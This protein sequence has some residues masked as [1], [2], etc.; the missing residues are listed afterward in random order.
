VTEK[1]LSRIE[2]SLKITLPDA[3][4][5]LISEQAGALKESRAFDGDCPSFSLDAKEVI[6]FNKAERPKDSGTGYAFPKWWSTFVLIGT[7]G[8]GDYYCLRLDNKPGVWMI[9]SDC[10]D[11]P[12]RVARS[13]KGFVQERL[14]EHQEEQERAAARQEDYHEENAEELKAIAESGDPKAKQWLEAISPYAM[15]PALDNIGQRVS[16]R[17]LRLYGIACCRRVANLAADDELVQ[18]VHLAE[19][20]VAG[21]ATTQD[22]ARLRA[23]LTTKHAAIRAGEE[24][25]PAGLWGV[26]AATNLLQDDSHYF[27]KDQIHAGDGDLLRVWYSARSAASDVDLEGTVQSDLLREV[28]GNP[29]VPVRFEPKWRTAEVLELAG[30]IYDKLSFEKMP[31][32]A[33]AL[34]RAGCANPRILKH[35]MR[36]PTHVRGCWVLDLILETEPEPAK[37]ELTWDFT[38]EYPNV[39]AS[40]L[41]TR[42]LAFGAD[43]AREPMAADDGPALSFADWLERNGDPAWAKYIRLRC[44][45]DGKAPGEDYPEFLEQLLESASGMRKRGAKFPGFYFSGYRFAS[46]EWWGDETDD[47]QRGIPWSVGA[48]SPSAG[49]RPVEQLVKELDA[50]FRTTPVRGINFEW[51]YPNEMAEILCSPP[52][53]QLRWLKFANRHPEGQTGPVIEAMVKSPVVKNLER[54][55]LEEGVK[56]DGDACA[57]AGA[58]FEQLRRLDLTGSQRLRCSADAATRLM[59]APWF[60]KLE[61]L[62]IGFSQACGEPGALHL[63]GLP[64][65]HSLGVHN[66]SDEEALAISR[67]GEFPALRRLFVSLAK[68]TG[69]SREAFCQWKPRGLVELWLKISKAKTADVSALIAAPLFEKLRVLTFQGPM[70]DARGLEALAAGPCASQLRILRLFCGND[71]LEGTFQSLA[72]TSLTRPGAFP[73]L[74][75][76]MIKNP[77]AKKAKRDCA[78]FLRT[79]ATPKL[80]HLTLIDLHFDDESANALA[81]SPTFDNLKRLKLEPGF[82]APSPLTPTA[83]ER[84]FR[85]ST[86]QNLVEVDLDGF[87]LGKSLEVLADESIM[88]KLRRGKFWGTKAP[89][90]TSELFKTKRPVI[91]VS[92]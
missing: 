67:A 16:P 32:L 12:T 73:E 23:R 55:S 61:H 88:S 75:T 71:K 33:D 64:N 1:E 85:S 90:E 62:D 11:T 36:K 77:Y 39:E 45:L 91:T 84:M 3:Y 35:C 17:K 9:G 50:L 68:L 60:R 18:A 78:E 76:L 22:V 28:L 14:K 63:S 92:S 53:R 89:S 52:A 69:E 7:N 46:E 27:N 56:S 48:V 54:L 25:S 6:R 72:G 37:V 8:G 79:L 57:L 87:A 58:G 47:L 80:R 38:W 30:A 26:S 41:K 2:T 24:N 42:V 74:T 15:F 66:L 70:L 4:R 65:L 13:L 44:A 5:K 19:A 86:L 82:A 31:A 51:H 49:T 21:K 81:T 59:T 40:K 29:F 10:G 83:A 34:K 43:A 20:M